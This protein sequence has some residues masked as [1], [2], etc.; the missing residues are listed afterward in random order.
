MPIARV[1]RDASER[2]KAIIVW[3]SSTYILIN[4]QS[5]LSQY[6]S[7]NLYVKTPMN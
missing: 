4:I 5:L 6:A 7:S 3:I 1:A 2:E